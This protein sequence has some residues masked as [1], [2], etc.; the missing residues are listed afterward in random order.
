MDKTIN[1]LL[2]EDDPDD[3]LLLM[4]LMAGQ[5]WP[6]FTFAFTCA[7]NL[8][9]GLK[10]LH[11]GAFEVVL[12]DL[13]L[14]ESRGIETV[15]RVRA[16]SPDIPIVVLTG[17]SD[18]K[19]GLEALASGAQD[20]QVKGNISGH[21][22]KRTISF[23]VERH[24]LTAGLRNTIENAPDGMVVIDGKGAIR[25]VN[26]AAERF[27]T[28]ERLLPGKPFPHPLP[29]SGQGEIKLAGDGG[30]ERCAEIRLS[31]IQWG[32]QS[33][34]LALIRDI[35]ELR[36]LEELRAEIR[37]SRRMDK[38]KDELISSIS[39]EMRSPLAIVKAAICNLRDG[40]AGPLLDQQTDMVRLAHRNVM[41]LER[42]V[43]NVLDLSRLE[44]GRA[45]IKTCSVDPGRL[46]RDAL[47]GF[48]LLA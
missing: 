40:L 21:A 17:L 24:R 33:A 1:G 22:L 26:P 14:P 23:A 30:E 6:A 25:Y 18:E 19:M 11:D 8:Q 43:D 37:E 28:P 39:H 27:F 16:Q 12:L 2:I 44:S 35:T 13:M 5:S 15:R 7:E 38:L 45:L 9:S 31:D 46:L 34:K 3:T 10:L 47:T 48:E 36:R 42:I 41:R 4:E 29:A 32:D 20:Y